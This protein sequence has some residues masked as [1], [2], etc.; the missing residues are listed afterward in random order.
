MAN[1]FKNSS[2]K[3]LT[4][5]TTIYACPAATQSVVFGLYFSNVDGTNDSS[6]T[7]EVFDNS[8][9]LTRTL[10][11][12]IPVP[13]GSTVQFGKITLEANDILKA[14]APIINDIEAFANILE[15]TA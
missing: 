5:S 12:G 11:K 7:V 8:T 3:L 14:F 13:I 2:A 6:F 1:A 9:G 15:V 4:T 10:G